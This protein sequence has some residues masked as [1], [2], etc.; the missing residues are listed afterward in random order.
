[1][2]IKKIESH[3]IKGHAYKTIWLNA[4]ENVAV[5]DQDKQ[6]YFN[7][8]YIGSDQ[9]KWQANVGNYR[10]IDYK[11]LYNNIDAKVYSEAFVDENRLHH[12][13]NRKS[14]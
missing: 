4:N 3:I 2:C 12:S 10:I 5:S 9:T 14:I 7:N 1:M 11:N 13:S 6:P 8:Y